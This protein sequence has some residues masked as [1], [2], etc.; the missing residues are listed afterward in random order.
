MRPTL[1]RLRHALLFEIIALALVAP[2]GGIIFG[3]GLGHFGVVAVVST[4]IAMA[5]NYLYNLAFDHALLRI[6]LNLN[7]SMPVRLI[8]AVLFE[9]GLI[10][11][12]VPFIAW[13]LDV[14]LWRA[15]IMDVVLAG[16]YMIYA[17][18]FN[19]AYDEIFPPPL[20]QA[21]R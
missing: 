5:W 12:L 1:D 16:F 13:Y 17:F 7:K 21:T 4:T 18:A 6:G 14:S 3:V 15:F 20:N 10:C 2:I 8:H 19:W 11:L 9:A